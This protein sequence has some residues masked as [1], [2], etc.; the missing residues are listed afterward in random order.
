MQQIDL[1]RLDEAD[2]VIQGIAT[3]FGLDFMPQEFDLVPAQKMLEIMAYRLPVNFS[4]WSFGR[5][6]EIERTRHEHGYAVP[7]EVVFNSDPCRAYL[8]ETN[9]FPIQVMVMAHVYAHNDFMKNSRHFQLT[10]RDMI[11]SAS[12]AAGRLRRYEEDYGLEAVEKLIDAGMAIQWNIDPGEPIHNETE[13]HTRER[14]YG[15]G[16]LLP[17]QGT[18]DDLLPAKEKPS[19]EEKVKLRKKSPP[20]PTIDLLGY[21]TEH[22]P[23]SLQEWEKDVLAI[24]R[25]Q[26]QYFMPY[27]RTK[28][29]NEGWATYWH[30][31][32]MQR[33]FTDR[34]LT[35]EEHGYYNLYNARVKAHHRRM[36]NPYLLGCALFGSIESRW[37]K[38]RFGQEYEECTDAQD[39]KH[40]DS[41]VMKGRA[42]IFEVRRT[43]MDWFFVDEFLNKEVV[44]D[45]DLYTYQE[46]DH[47]THYESVV[48]ETDW[49]KV[50]KTL[51]QSLMNWGIPRILVT[52]GNY[53]GSLQLYLKHAFEGLVLDDEYCRK[54][55]EYLY[56]LWDRPVFLET[57]EPRK[58]RVR[59]KIYE[60]NERGIRVR[61]D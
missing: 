15:W 48:D 53:Q 11:S 49:T 19:P 61:S 37:N 39:K 29:M 21:I 28:I 51:V 25:N 38:G 30:E 34:F 40:W 46:K 16:K 55:L 9:P 43:H 18:F 24:I 57:G 12:E 54:T 1:A 56:Y 59:R 52:D 4:H 26:A 10:R 5:D 50:K 3:G 32:I 47:Y 22:S 20:E 6:Y 58:Y 35:A 23:R 31:K 33:L 36:V 17:A 41:A 14:L 7:Y 42:K 13:E 2:R 8:M 27:R 45:L 44:D 60:I